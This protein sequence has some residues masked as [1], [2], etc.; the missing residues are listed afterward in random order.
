[1]VY[2]GVGMEHGYGLIGSRL[3]AWNREVLLLMADLATGNKG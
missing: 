2:E 3:F 1:M